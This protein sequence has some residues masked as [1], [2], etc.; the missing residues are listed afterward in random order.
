LV[1]WIFLATASISRCITTADTNTHTSHGIHRGAYSQDQ[2]DQPLTRDQPTNRTP[3]HSDIKRPPHQLLLCNPYRLTTHKP[4]G[5]CIW[6]QDIP[7]SHL[8]VQSIHN[9]AALR[10]SLFMLQGCG[11]SQSLCECAHLLWALPMARPCR[12]RAGPL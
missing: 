2:V 11:A 12:I 4:R 9:Q 10:P 8:A 3:T 5:I 1:A 6:M 7:P